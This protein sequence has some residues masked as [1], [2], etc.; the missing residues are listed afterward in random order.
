MMEAREK[1]GVQD[2]AINSLLKSVAVKSPATARSKARSVG[3]G[4]GE[5]IERG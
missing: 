3:R 4:R 5:N 1:N 2:D